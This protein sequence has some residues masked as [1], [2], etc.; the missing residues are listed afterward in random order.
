MLRLV[1]IFI[2]LQLSACKNEIKV[3]LVDLGIANNRENS[4]KISTPLS[5]S[6]IAAGVTIE[7]QETATLRIQGVPSGRWHSIPLRSAGALIPGENAD[8]CSSSDLDNF[9]FFGQSA[10]H[11]DLGLKETAGTVIFGCNLPNGQSF[12]VEIDYLPSSL[13]IVSSSSQLG[14]NF[15]QS[16]SEAKLSSSGRYV[17]FVASSSVSG[18]NQI[19]RK[20]LE[21][22]ELLIVSGFGSGTG[23]I[24][25]NGPSSAPQISAD[26]R[27]V[28]FA[29]SSSNFVTGGSGQQVYLKD[30]QNPASPPLIV[31]SLDSSQADQTAFRGN[32]SSFNPQISADGRYVVFASSSS[33]FVTGGSGQQVYIKDLQN[34]ASPPLMVSS[35]DSTQAD[36][37]AFRG[38]N[39]SSTPQISADGRY[40]VF[41]SFASNFVTG[42]SGTH[43]YLKD[44][45]NPATPPLMVSSL[46]ST[47]ANQTA[48][49]GSSTSSTPQISADGRYV[50]FSSQSS[51]FV[52]GGSGSQ[53]YRKDLQNPA[54]PP[55]IVSSLDSTQAN[56][57]TFRGNNSSTNPQ[58]SAD[59]RYVVFSS[60]SSNFVTGGSGQQIY[61]K[62]LQNPA[63][64]PLMVSSLDSMQ[65]DQT[66]FRGNN[67][68]SNPQISADGRYVVF[69]SFASNFVTGGSGG[70]IYHKDLQNPATP[71]LIVS[72][73]DS[74]Q[75]NQTAFRGNSTSSTP[76]IS[77]DGRYVVF[78]SSPSNFVIGGSGGQIYRKDLQNPASPPLLV[79]SL[80]STQADQTAFRG[81]NITSSPQ[82]SADGRY[83][84]FSS[85]SSNFVTGGSGVQIYRKDLQN[86]AN[87]PL[88]VS[89][90]DSTQADQTVFRGNGS[91]SGS[92]ISADGRYVV[93]ISQ[94]S[95]FV[96]GGSGQQIYLK[97]LQ[98]PASPPQLISSLDSTQANQTAFRGNGSSTNPQISADGRYVV[99]A[100][101]SSNFVTGGSGQQIYLKDLQNPAS[102]PLMV[103]SLD[104]TQA[105]QTAFRGNNTSSTPQISADGRYVVFESFASNFIT[106]G[107]G[108]QIY[109]KDLQNPA[110]PPLMVS[111][112]DSTQTD[113]TTFRGDGGSSTS[114]ISADGRYVVFASFSS[115]FITGGTGYQIYLKDLQ[116]PASPPLMV[117]SLDS[118]QADQT[119]LGGN[120]FSSAPQI[121]ADGRYVVFASSSS[122][123]VT[124]VSGEQIYLK[125]LD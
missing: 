107:S 53:I 17:V 50:V 5:A 104:S 2:L 125:R 28:V 113:Q 11:F 116:N 57:T 114:Q 6:W 62:E 10:L 31:S 106:G 21:T 36:Q 65:A 101:S 45:Q 95:N 7:E 86:P 59:G 25:G 13:A 52:T 81:N 64:P 76:Q 94:S 121:S 58:I 40:V 14:F 55:L 92:Q 123:F 19:F 23:I 24:F 3:A 20:D 42:G 87:P 100:S 68:S 77:A 98:N 73:L 15:F 79:S 69:S 37:T 124:G 48:Y 110:T 63:S 119:A 18:L 85:Q 54:T 78:S 29:S 30:L 99:F 112:I 49:R 12:Q 4:A 56:Q 91:S 109:L 32:N 67:T 9:A 89:S 51:N 43:V 117:S 105:D 60:Q 122:N 108:F 41:E 93:F 74:T 102:P 82:I 71:P 44:L 22:D 27:Y 75:A 120:S 70:Q 35:L 84:V 90:L 88:L 1:F 16:S 47:Q 61:L 83:V 80:D 118:T 26:G 72:S 34:P 39:T 97:D 46:D 103:S 96:I 38:N 111:S 66:A 8:V 33:N 115:N